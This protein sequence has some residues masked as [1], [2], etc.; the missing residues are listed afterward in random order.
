MS[1]KSNHSKNVILVEKGL[2][3]DSVWKRWLGN[4]PTDMVC[5]IRKRL[6]HKIPGLTEKF[7][8]QSLYLGYWT[9]EDKDRAYIYVQKKGLRIDLCIDRNFESELRK[10]GF[11]V[12]Y[13]NN[14]QGKAGWLTG[15]HVKESTDI[16]TILK[17]FC[18]AFEK[19]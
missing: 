17:W 19:E 15:W 13:V 10:E 9:G 1:K 6:S 3:E 2:L 18:K 14:Y 12:K 8:K 16:E 11:E 5:S 7:N 4:R